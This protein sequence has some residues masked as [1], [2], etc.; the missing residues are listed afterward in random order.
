MSQ[1]SAL[2]TGGFEDFKPGLTELAPEFW[3]PLRGHIVSKSGAL[4]WGG[5]QEV[6][7]GLNAIGT[8]PNTI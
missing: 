8:A 4:D 6:E 5:S 1:T 3:K 7:T 2:D